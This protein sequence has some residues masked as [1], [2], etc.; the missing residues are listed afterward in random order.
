MQDVDA[1]PENIRCVMKSCDG[2]GSHLHLQEVQADS[3]AGVRKP[4]CRRAC[5][6]SSGDRDGEEG[7]GWERGEVGR[8]GGC[9]SGLPPAPAAAH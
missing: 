8:R 7:T 4:N 3:Y 5:W 6:F 2:R 1:L 9:G